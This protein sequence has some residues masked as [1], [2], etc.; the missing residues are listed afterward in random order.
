[1]RMINETSRLFAVLL[2]SIL[3]CPSLK[4][5][6]QK[7]A[8]PSLAISSNLLYDATSS[9]NLGVEFKVGSR[10]TLGLPVSYNPFSFSD[11]KK[12][13]HILFQPELRRWFCSPFS[14]HFLGLHTH[15]GYYN[16]GGIGNHYMK[17]NR[18][19]GW[20]VGGGFTYGYQ[21]NMGRSWNLEL[22]AGV[23]YAYLD[24]KRYSCKTC[25]DYKGDEH[26]HYFGPTKAAVS[27]IYIIN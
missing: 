22:S 26:K 17:A 1:M 5:Q 25:G 12:W 4:G 27:F 14:G 13:K 20:L 23:G 6:E 16:V 3:L 8:T 10:L 11:N 21:F 24:Y 15:Y 2:F 19:Q 18:F 9:F 7:S